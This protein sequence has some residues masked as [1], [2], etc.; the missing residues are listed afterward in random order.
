MNGLHLIQ[1][2]KEASYPVTGTPLVAFLGD[3]VYHAVLARE[4]RRINN[5]LPVSILN[6]GV[7]GDSA[8]CALS[9][10]DR[11][12]IAR[13]PDLCV[14]NFALND[15]NDP[16]EVYRASLGEV[17]DR[18]AAAGIPV[19]L[20]TPNM[21]NTYVHPDTI[22]MYR[23]YAAVTADYQN[24]GRMDAYVDAAR[25]LA[26]ERDIPVADTY[27]RWKSLAAAGED[28]TACLANYINHPTRPMHR[29]FAEALL[30]VLETV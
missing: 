14:V 5:W 13:R 2:L 9:R 26:A 4:L 21:M 28:T 3:A 11:D 6:A 16:L 19:I 25:A 22:P 8:K 12:V 20:L 18:L 1:Y 15:V 30:E 29:L 23:A 7:A 17:F 10:I 24:S 27:R